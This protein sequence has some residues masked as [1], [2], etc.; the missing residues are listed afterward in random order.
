MAHQVFV[1]YASPDGAAAQA[2]C[3][4]L[5]D[6]GVRCWIA[7]R[8]IS[9]GS[10]WGGSI[11]EAI[12][13]SKAVVVVF[14]EKSNASPQVSR[15]MECAVAERLPLVPVRIDDCTYALSPPAG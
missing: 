13:A 5:E 9:P 6:A 8:D 10:Q 4:A 1:S 2:I 11:V 3:Q 14:S 7:P 12:K 15:E